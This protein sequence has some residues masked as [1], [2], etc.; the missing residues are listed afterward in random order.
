MKLTKVIINSVVIK[1]SNGSPDPKKVI[2]WQYEKDDS[3]ISEAEIIVP[4]NISDLVDLTNGQV[5]EIHGG[6]TTS[7]DKRIFYGFIDNIKPNGATV[8]ITCKNEMIALVRKNVNHV[9]D[10]SI[11]AS[12][13]EVSEIVEDLIETYG[14]LSATVQASGTDD[15][16]RIDQFKCI[17][18]DVFERVVSLKDALDWDLFYDDNTRVVFFQPNGFI[19]SQKLLTVGK[20]IIGMPEW[21]IDDSNM[22]NVLTVIGASV[23]TNLTET[24]RIGTTSGYTTDS[25][26]LS[27][28][29]DSVELYM[30][31]ANP[32]TTQKEGGSK[33]ASISNFFYVDKENKKVIPA[34]GTTFTT[35]HYAIVN[36]IWSAE[37]P[38]RMRNQS[39]IDKYGFKEKTIELKDIT[40]VSDAEARAYS[41]LTKRSVPYVSGIM[42]IKSIAANI[43][44][45]GEM[46]EIVD[47]KTPTVNGQV[48]S[49][50]YVVS[51][52]KYMFPSAYEEI[53]VGDSQWGLADW[54]QSTE[55]RLKRIEEEFFRNQ[56]IIVELVD[57][58]NLPAVTIKPRYTKV[59]TE[60]MVN[61]SNFI[62]GHPSQGLLGSDVLGRQ[63]DV[64]ADYFVQQ[65]EN[66]YTETFIDSDFNDIGV[67]D[68]T[69]ANDG[70]I[71]FTSGQIAQSLPI[72]LNN[73]QITTATLTSTEVS[74]SFDYE[75][76]ANGS[77][78]ESVTSGVAHTFTYTTVP[79]VDHR[80]TDLRWRATENAASTG[81]I[82]K[83][84]VRSYH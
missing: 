65:Y 39:S 71:T 18:T 41:I 77:D 60:T 54:Q 74:G 17:N 69:W 9:Y 49:G 66:I 15:G 37:M 59:L 14:G 4:R 38:V 32:P 53:E 58:Q 51:K 8:K 21:D 31:A 73:T 43:P 62:L 19:D 28:T 46:V 44:N 67:S 81:E 22:I 10:S 26:L 83:I 68:C 48:L 11:D 64:S 57:V 47:T 3:E 61:G 63:A 78:W 84:E 80:G 20:E 35:N 76:T 79:A 75:M 7:T 52:V 6:W 29:P 42:K 16:K 82:S 24:G 33:D 12:A 2:S 72:D 23:P 13:G 27:N 40:S 56:D 45:R 36:Y 5:V 30:D 55:E 70:S 25:I 50:R 34:T 1:D